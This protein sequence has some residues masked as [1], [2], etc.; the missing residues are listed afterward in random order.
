MKLRFMVQDVSGLDASLL[1]CFELDLGG[2]VLKE[3]F[4]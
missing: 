3:V 1:K 4:T 2:R